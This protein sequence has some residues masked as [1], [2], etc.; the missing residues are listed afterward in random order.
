MDCPKQYYLKQYYLNWLT[1][2]FL[3]A[4]LLQMTVLCMKPLSFYIIY[5]VSKPIY[6]TSAESIL[7]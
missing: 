6:P 4:I 7:L 2:Y 3:F 5:Y 1:A